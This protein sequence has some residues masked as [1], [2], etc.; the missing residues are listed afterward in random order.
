MADERRIPEVA[1]APVTEDNIVESDDASSALRTVLQKAIEVNGLVRG[2]SATARALDKGVAQL[3][4][5]ADDCEE[6][7]YKNLITALARQNKVNL[8]H[9]PERRLLGELAGL[10]K[11]D[12]DNNI[13]KVISTS[14]VAVTDFGEGTKALDRV[15]REFK[16]DE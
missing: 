2:I 7:E 16:K 9:I 11:F 10:A 15:L 12:R 4:V 3:C 1:D 6:E 8:I 14:T 5:L 13:K